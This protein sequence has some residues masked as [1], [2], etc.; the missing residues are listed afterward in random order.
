MTIGMIFVRLPSGYLDA[1]DHHDRT[2]YV[3]GRMDRIGYHGTGMCND[4][5]Q[6]L[7]YRKYEVRHDADHG[8][9]HSCFLVILFHFQILSIPCHPVTTLPLSTFEV[10]L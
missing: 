6:K 4:T 1:D 7:E 5:G 3:G 10:T 9:P 2:E 8:D